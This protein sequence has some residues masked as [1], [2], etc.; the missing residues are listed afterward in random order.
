MLGDHIYRS[1]GS[2]SCARQVIEAYQQSGT[3]V[4][5]LRP[6]PESEIGS[7]GVATGVWVEP[8]RKLM[9]TEFAEK[10]T[11]DYARNHLRVPDLDDTEYL[12]VFGQYVIKP[13]LFDYLEE[14][15]RHNV[16]ERGEFQLTS[17]LDRLRV[18]DGFQG[19]IVEGRRFDIGLPHSYID[20]LAAFSRD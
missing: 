16:R 18:E 2:L 1:N 12:T 10:P 3:S 9:I 4:V 7:F 15:I 20:T 14:H 8:R 5:G 19:L 6:T 13:L 11:V 17:A